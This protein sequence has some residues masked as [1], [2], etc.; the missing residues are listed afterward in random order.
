[1]TIFAKG[2][3]YG[4]ADLCDT[5]YD[6]I[7]LDWTMDVK[8]ASLVAAAKG[9]AL[10]GNLDPAALYGDAESVRKLT[11]KMLKE[12]KSAGVIANLGHGMHP[13]FEPAKLAAFVD[14]VHEF[15]KEQ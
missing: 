4:V 15:E 5:Q 10:Q 8:E 7:G 14:A 3:H 6:V 2:A 12:F 9:K 13:D 1:M 11:L